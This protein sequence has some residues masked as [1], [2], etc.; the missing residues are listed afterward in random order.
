MDCQ[1]N[2]ERA[3]NAIAV[4]ESNDETKAAIASLGFVI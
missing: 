3:D 2:P 1:P 4:A